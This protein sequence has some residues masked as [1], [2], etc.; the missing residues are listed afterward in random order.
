MSVIEREIERRKAIVESKEAKLAELEEHKKA[1]AKL[2]VEIS[3]IDVETLLAEV[4]E[5]EEIKKRFA[6]T[7]ETVVQ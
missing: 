3:E 2:E 6:E 5:L 1:V 7:T 4:E